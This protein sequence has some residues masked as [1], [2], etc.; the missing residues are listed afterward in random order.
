[1][2]LLRGSVGLVVVLWLHSDYKCG[3]GRCILLAIYSPLLPLHSRSTSRFPIDKEPSI[4][5]VPWWTKSRALH[6]FFL[7]RPIQ[8]ERRK[9]IGQPVEG[10]QLFH[11]LWLPEL[12]IIK[13][14]LYMHSGAVVGPVKSRRG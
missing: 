1:M 4:L 8:W 9:R 6:M 3:C 10:L 12:I 11:T 13:S 2:A 7:F 5:R 14:V